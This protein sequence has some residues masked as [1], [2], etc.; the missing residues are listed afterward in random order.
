MAHLSEC[1]VARD[2]GG[3]ISVSRGS[4]AGVAGNGG[5]WGAFLPL[6]AAVHM[7]LYA[8]SRG[9]ESGMRRKD[10]DGR[11]D[12]DSGYPSSYLDW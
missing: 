12:G 4:R 8:R 10:E 9:G 3:V 5:R 1:S 7:I 2:G 6:L 11:M